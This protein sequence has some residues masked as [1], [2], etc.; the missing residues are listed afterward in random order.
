MKKKNITHSKV[1]NTGILFEMLVRQ[2]TVDVLEDTPDSKSIALMKRYFNPSTQLGQELQ[3]YRS[4]FEI[5]SLTETKA[6]KFV[7]IVTDQ[8]VKLN[9]KELAQEKYNLVKEIKEEY[10]DNFFKI[11]VPSYKIYAS[12]YSYKIYN[13][14]FCFT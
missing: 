8:H 7:D 2:I 12:I 13:F 6:A 14:T 11:K 5:G 10:G 4:F 9:E 3:L 1:K